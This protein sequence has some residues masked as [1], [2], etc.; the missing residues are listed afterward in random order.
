METGGGQA[1][2]VSGPSLMFLVQSLFLLLATGFPD[3]TFQFS[4]VSVDLFDGIYVHH[5]Q[6]Y[7]YH[8]SS[9][10]SEAVL[11]GFQAFGQDLRQAVGG[12]PASTM[13]L[14]NGFWCLSLHYLFS[15]A[16]CVTEISCLLLQSHVFVQVFM[17]ATK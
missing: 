1:L 10:L 11:L 4:W 3:Q 2:G 17:S 8:G 9:R 6:H 12:L 15:P 5:T 7:W 14:L 16:P 13:A